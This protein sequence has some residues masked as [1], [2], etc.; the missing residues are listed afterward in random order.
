MYA[1]LAF[2]LTCIAVLA[3]VWHTACGRDTDRR[4]GGGTESDPRSARDY[5]KD[6]G[7]R[8]SNLEAA[9]RRTADLL[10]EQA[11]VIERTDR[12]IK[13]S[14]QLVEKAKSILAGARHTD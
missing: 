1:T 7:Q 13:K 11:E 9:E 10:R 5:A 8:N 14:E 12:G 4:R 2:I 3:I 6:A